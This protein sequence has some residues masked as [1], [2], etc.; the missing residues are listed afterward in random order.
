M[1]CQNCS[2]TANC[3]CGSTG[4]VPS[5]TAN[6]PC[7]TTPSSVCCQGLTI[8][9]FNV[10][11]AKTICGYIDRIYDQKIGQGSALF[12]V[13]TTNTTDYSISTVL[14]PQSAN[15]CT[16]CSI[17]AGATFFPADCQNSV[18]LS[19]TTTIP[20]S[21]SQVLVNGATI[22]QLVQNS[23]GSYTAYLGT[24]NGVPVA[25]CE[26]QGL[27]TRSTL[28]IQNVTSWTYTAETKLYGTMNYNGQSC[29]FVITVDNV[30]P[31]VTD[32]NSSTFI[33]QNLCIP[34]QKATIN[35][36]LTGSIT[37]V[38]PNITY[39]STN[40]IVVIT[41]NG[42]ILPQINVEVLEKTKVCVQ[43]LL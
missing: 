30:S 4:N 20:I 43:A 31:Q 16:P 35:F 13:I 42:V 17:G 10:A 12:D 18:L 23:D 36:N 2:P 1:S 5:S 34:S 15:C 8:P 26:A 19:L 21:S 6:F 11:K 25:S 28:M 29:N 9:K 37:L 3:N 27:G 39:D 33:V 32:T 14:T 7:T 24:N 41:A 40:N 38:N 22:P